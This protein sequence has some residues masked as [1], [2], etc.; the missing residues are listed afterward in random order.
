[1]LAKIERIL[2]INA[3]DEVTKEVMEAAREHLVIADRVSCTD[4][5]VARYWRYC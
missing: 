1:M 3:I 5:V 4:D 2:E